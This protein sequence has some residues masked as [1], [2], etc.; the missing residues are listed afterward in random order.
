MAFYKL[1]ISLF[2]EKINLKYVSIISKLFPSLGII[3]YKQNL[4]YICLFGFFEQYKSWFIVLKSPLVDLRIVIAVFPKFSSN[5]KKNFL[6]RISFQT[7]FPP[8]F[9]KNFSQLVLLYFSFFPIL[10]INNHN[11]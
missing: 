11:R 2:K 1:N 5:F 6:L 7:I 3:F 10:P 8:I 4:I 9:K